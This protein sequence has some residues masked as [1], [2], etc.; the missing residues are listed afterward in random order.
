MRPQLPLSGT[1]DALASLKKS[2]ILLALFLV[3]VDHHWW[4]LC[5]ST[6]RATVWPYNTQTNKPTAVGSLTDCL[7]LSNL[8]T[9]TIKNVYPRHTVTPL[10]LFFQTRNFRSN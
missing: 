5:Q 1:I 2:F 9:F 6:S 7:H 10:C 4:L 8:L 3:T